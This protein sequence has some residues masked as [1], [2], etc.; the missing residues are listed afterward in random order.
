MAVSI[1]FALFMVAIT[2]L[3][4]NLAA[5]PTFDAIIIIVSR[6]LTIDTKC[7]TILSLVDE[8]LNTVLL[9]QIKVI[10][11]QIY[12]RKIEISKDGLNGIF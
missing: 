7:T 9:I 10:Q 1:E 5:P 3:R 6:T 2:G 12:Y 11:I 8:S 4:S